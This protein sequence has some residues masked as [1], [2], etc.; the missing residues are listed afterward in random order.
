VGNAAFNQVQFDILG[1]I[2][3]CVFEHTRSRDSLSER[4]WRIVVQAVEAALQCW[5]GPDRGIWEVRG[6]PQNFTFSKVMCWVAADRGARLAA[7]RGEKDRADRWWKG[8]KEIHADVC[9]KGLGEQGYFTQSYES[10][11][12]DASL[13]LLPLLGFL[14]PNDERI[15]KTVMAIA[16]NLSDG[17]FVYR[18]RPETTDDGISGPNEGSF[19]VCSFWLV[20]ALV[21]IGELDRAR[22]QCEKLIGASSNLGLFG[23][24]LDPSTARHLGNFPQAL[25][26]LSLINAVLHVIEADQRLNEAVIGPAG[27][28][29]WWGGAG[30]GDRTTT[31]T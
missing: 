25:T 21:E 30:N 28:P 26:H 6:E 31:I 12:L 4:S 10:S 2:V 24:E 20:S 29:N 19:T 9:A 11:E 7:L 5:K 18:Y 27:S 8:A 13:L 15:R 16:D 1:A 17:A 3:D 14:P 23:E 22:T